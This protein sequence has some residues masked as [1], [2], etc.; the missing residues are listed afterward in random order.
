[1][2]DL[3]DMQNFYEEQNNAFMKQIKEEFNLKR[4]KY[5]EIAYELKI[6]RNRD[7]Q[8][9]V[10]KMELLEKSIKEKEIKTQNEIVKLKM[11]SDIILRNIK[12]KYEEE[13]KNLNLKNKKKIEDLQK[14]YQ[15]RVNENA[16]MINQLLEQLQNEVR[17]SYNNL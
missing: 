12:I 15:K 10:K 5:D 16:N 13:L 4:K 14:Q 17:N 8:A 6:K 7:H 3:E 11:E 1:M 2:K 9:Y